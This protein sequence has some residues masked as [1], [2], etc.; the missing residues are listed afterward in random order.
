MGL[1]LLRTSNFPRRGGFD[2]LPSR[3]T[4]A[5]SLFRG[6]HREL[7]LCEVLRRRC[8]PRRLAM[9]AGQSPF[10]RVLYSRWRRTIFIGW[11]NAGVSIHPS[12]LPGK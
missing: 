9:V 2:G 11:A 1:P 8:H 12:C 7:I 4:G 3:V 5:S 10:A 6:S